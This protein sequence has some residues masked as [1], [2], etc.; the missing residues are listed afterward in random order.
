MQIEK[1][2]L[3]VRFLFNITFS[4]P[5]SVWIHVYYKI[6]FKSITCK[7]L[8]TLNAFKKPV[9]SAPAFAPQLGLPGGQG[10]KGL[11]WKIFAFYRGRGS[12]IL[13]FL[14]S[15]KNYLIYSLIELKLPKFSN[16]S[17][18]VHL[19]KMFSHLQLTF[20]LRWKTGTPHK[21]PFCWPGPSEGTGEK[22]QQLQLL[23]QSPALVSHNSIPGTAWS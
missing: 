4:H 3:G 8:Q 15:W 2:K 17:I 9:C 1:W 20:V 22:G 11:W 21:F 14:E 23:W 12:I 6:Y 19:L 16:I 10:F 13:F 18:K 5:S 7:P